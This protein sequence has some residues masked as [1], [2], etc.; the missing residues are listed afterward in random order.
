MDQVLVNFWWSRDNSS[1]K[2]H[3][4]AANELRKPVADGGLGFRSF[5]DFNLAFT[6]KLA[7]K[8]LT[9]PGCLWVQL[10]K[11][12][13]YPNSDFLQASKHHRSS[14]IWSRIMEGRKALL[15]GLRKNIGDGYGTDII[16]AWIPEAASFKASCS[17]SYSTTK[18]SD[19]IINPQRIWNAVKLR[20]VFLEPVVRQILLIPLGPEGYADRLIWH[21]ESTGKFT[22][23]SCY[24]HLRA[25]TTSH[26]H[27][28]D[29]ST[30]K[31]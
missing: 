17:M 18:V 13:Y 30:K 20:T 14:W 24:K 7:W 31:M 15:H 6:A 3:W 22:V 4:L 8:I 21:Y 11:G 23:R 29:N 16:D 19:Y 10:L 27:P 28:V 12:I 9:Q 26:N 5:Y 2:I 1:K 25:I